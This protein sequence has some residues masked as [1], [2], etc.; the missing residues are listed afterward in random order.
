M[1]AT[2]SG[3]SLQNSCS[4]GKAKRLKR[5]VGAKVDGLATQE[6]HE[7]VKLVEAVGRGRVDGCADRQIHLC[8]FLHNR[9]HLQAPITRY[10]LQSK[11]P[12]AWLQQSD[13]MPLRTQ[14]SLGCVHTSLAVKESRP[15]VG[16]SMKSTFGSDTRAIPMLVR[17]HCPPAH[18]HHGSSQ[19]L[20]C[21]DAAQIGHWAAHA[22]TCAHLQALSGR[23]RSLVTASQRVAAWERPGLVLPRFTACKKL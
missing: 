20:H 19:P 23:R 13:A 2:R 18:A 9:H 22:R 7:A 15:E 1:L 17:L 5:T 4:V 21:H 11:V 16:S 10:R 14:Q 3:I 8:Q 6:Q 12:G